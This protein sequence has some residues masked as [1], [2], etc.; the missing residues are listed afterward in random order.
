[1]QFPSSYWLIYFLALHR[2][3]LKSDRQLLANF[4][5]GFVKIQEMY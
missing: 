1:M 2:T 4:Q 3:L 5:K